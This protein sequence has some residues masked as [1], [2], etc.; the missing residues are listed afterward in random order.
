MTDKPPE[1]DWAH[2]AE[3]ALAAAKECTSKEERRLLL[4]QAAFYAERAEHARWPRA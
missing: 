1:E 4:E 2:L 3:A